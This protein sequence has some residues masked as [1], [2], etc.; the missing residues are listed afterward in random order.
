MA[1]KKKTNGVV[2]RNGWE[3]KKEF[4]M[5]ADAIFVYEEFDFSGLVKSRVHSLRRHGYIV[6]CGNLRCDEGGYDLRPEI[7]RLMSRKSKRAKVVLLQCDGWEP[8]TPR[9]GG[10]CTG[11]IEGT[12]VL[13][14]NNTAI[15]VGQS[16][17]T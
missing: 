15:A 10:V 1:R 13:K 11:S 6:E 4:P 7:K 5:L 2:S 3:F 17:A 16:K 8:K 12:L 9:S 14:M